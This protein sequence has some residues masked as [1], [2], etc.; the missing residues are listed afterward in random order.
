MNEQTGNLERAAELRL[1]VAASPRDAQ[2]WRLLGQALN[3]APTRDAQAVLAWLQAVHLGPEDAGN[4][5]GLAVAHERLGNVDEAI[6]AYERAIALKPE[7]A[8]WHLA[9]ARALPI[10]MESNAQVDHHRARMTSSLNAIIA[11][12]PAAFDFN[13]GRTHCF[14]SAYHNR[15]DRDLQETLA[16][17]H[18]AVASNLA[19]EAPHCSA[20][21]GPTRGRRIKLGVLSAYLRRHSVGKTTIGLVQ[22]LDRERFELTLLRP[23]PAPDDAFAATFDASAD[24]VVNLPAELEDARNTIASLGLDIIFY[25]DVGMGPLAYYLAYARLAP[26]QCVSWGHS[27]TS[28]IPNLDYYL[29]SDLAEPPDAEDHYSEELVRLG[30]SLVC[31]RKPPV[32]KVPRERKYFGLPPEGALYICP[33][34]LFRLHPDFDQALGALL[35]SD[36]G[37]HLVFVNRPS[38]YW[39]R[40]LQRRFDYSMRDVRDRLITL[41]GMPWEDFLSLLRLGDCVLDPPNFSGCNA[42]FD[43]FSAGVPIVAWANALFLR[44]RYTLAMYRMMGIRDCLAHSTDDFVS[45]AMR[46][47]HDPSFRSSI[48]GAINARAD[49]LFDDRTV[50]RA[51]EDFWC[52]AVER[53][54]IDGGKRK[55]T[56]RRL[57]ASRRQLAN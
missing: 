17:A 56:E 3:Q 9:S 10:I 5:L 24:R 26:V 36:P 34:T 11:N 55:A 38:P 44:G 20:P 22:E 32:P 47:A 29:S 45:I 33:H 49:M 30:G 27:N 42:S 51:H 35:R 1:A 54:R 46:L 16:R 18:L 52:E 19:W 41:G 4:W 25:P 50:V 6:A 53:S 21:V 48:R 23:E 28:G 8:A 40:S 7:Q 12:P 2:A 14:Y 15:N 31:Y 39:E 57:W 13:F 43:A 37:S